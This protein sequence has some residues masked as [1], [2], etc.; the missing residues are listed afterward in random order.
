MSSEM[1]DYELNGRI[2]KN[3]HLVIEEKDIPLDPQDVTIIVR[4][5]SA[6]DRKARFERLKALQGSLKDWGVDGVE[7]Q[8]ELRKEWD[9][10]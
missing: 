9:N 2:D 1:K 3:H 4:P 7:Y 6:E 10:R 5:K 8:R